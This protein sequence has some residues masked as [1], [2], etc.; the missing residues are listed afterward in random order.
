M[1]RGGGTLSPPPL[2]VLLPPLDARPRPGSAIARPRSRHFKPF[3][4]FLLAAAAELEKKLAEQKKFEQDLKR[5]S[6]V[7]DNVM[8]LTPTEKRQKRIYRIVRQKAID[9]R[10]PPGVMPGK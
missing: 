1:R 9:T 10:L 8:S 2:H 3:V 4:V 5:K 7:L 6:Q